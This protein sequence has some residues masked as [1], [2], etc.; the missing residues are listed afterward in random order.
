MESIKL[1]KKRWVSFFDRFRTKHPVIMEFLVFFLV[2]NGVTVF[3]MIVMPVLKLLFENTVLVSTG[4]QFL[5][6]GSVGGE[7]YFVFDYA[8]GTIKSGGGGGLAYFLA[9]EIAMGLAQVIN[10][11]LQRNVTFKSTG[12]VWKAAFWYLVAYLMI[13]I[14][15]AALQG[16]YKDPIYC[17][18]Q[19]MMGS[20]GILFAD[21]ITM[22]INC[23]I[24]FWVYFPILKIIFRQ[25]KQ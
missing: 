10:F 24:S 14:G 25:K 22:I 7:P 17:L 15:A 19:E 4:I 21:L 8:A 18:L 20:K 1:V 12:S 13:S 2:S 5:Q 3:Q 16:V 6:A 9:V 11:Y 23:A